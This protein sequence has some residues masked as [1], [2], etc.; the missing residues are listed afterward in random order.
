MTW[1]RI[2]IF[3]SADWNANKYSRL[4]K[5]N[6]G[7]YSIT[8]N[9]FVD[10][11]YSQFDWQD[12]NGDGYPDL[13]L[14]G[15]NG[16]KECGFL[17]INS[18]DKPFYLSDTIIPGSQKG[19][20]GFGDVDND[21][22]LDAFVSGS[23]YYPSLNPYVI[24]TNT[25]SDSLIPESFTVDIHTIS[26]FQF[27]DYDNDNDLDF[28]INGKTEPGY[29]AFT[30][31]YQNTRS[32]N[33]PPNPPANIYSN[34]QGTTVYL[35]WDTASDN[36]TP[37]PIKS[38][39]YNIYVGTTSQG[40]DIVSPLASIP[41]GFRKIA[42]PGY[43]QDTA[44]T[45]K[46]LEAGTYYWGVQAIDNALGTSAFSIEDT[47]IIKDRF[48][49]SSFSE[50]PPVSS[51]AMFFDC[52]HDNDFDMVLN[53]FDNF[54]IASY[55]NGFDSSNYNLIFYET[56]NPIRTITPNDYNNDNL[57]DIS[58]SGDYT[59]N[60]SI[61]ETSIA[62]F[63]YNSPYN[64]TKQDSLIQDMFYD[65]VIWAD[66][67]NDGLQDFITSGLNLDTIP[68]TVIYQNSGNGIFI[69]ID[70]TI[71]GFNESGAVAA[72]FDNDMDI[73]IIIYG[74]DSLDNPNTYLYRN[75]GEFNFSEQ[76]IQNN[77]LFRSQP[78]FGIYSGDFDLNGK[79]DVYLV[80]QAT[81]SNYYVKVLL[82]NN[83]SFTDAN[84]PIK[85]WK[86]FTSNFWADY[87]YD[88][89]IDIF[90]TSTGNS[91]DETRLYINNNQQLEEKIY[92]LSAL[93]KL[94]QPFI[95]VNLDNQNGL[96]FLMKK[97]AGNYIQFFDNYAQ[98][99]K[100]TTAPA[101]LHAAMDSLDVVFSWD[102]LPDCPAC[103]YN[104]RVGTSPDMVDIM[105][106]M[107]DTATGF[108]YVI[109]PGNAYMNS[110]W[111]LK[112]LEPETYYW[113]VQAVDAAN[114]GGPWAPLQSFDVTVVN[115]AFTGTTVCL[116]DTTTFTD[117]SATS[118]GSIIEWNWDF[119]D[120]TTSALQNPVHVFDSA[121][122][123]LVKLTAYSSTSDS[124]TVE[125][126]VIVKPKP[127]ARF[128]STTVCQG[129]PT[130]FIKTGKNSGLNITN[131]LLQ[132]GDGESSTSLGDT[133]TQG[134]I[135]V[136]SFTSSLLLNADNGC[137]DSYQTTVRVGGLP[138]VSITD[139]GAI[140]PI[141]V[142]DTVRLSVKD[143]SD[144]TYA[145]KRNG[146]D[147]GIHENILEITREDES[148]VY[149]VNVTN[150]IGYCIAQSSTKNV[151]VNSLPNPPT[152]Q[153]SQTPVGFCQGDSIVLSVNKGY[154]AYSWKNGSGDDISAGKNYQYVAKST[155]DYSVEITNSDG[156]SAISA[157]TI[158]VT[159]YPSPAVPNLAFSGQQ[160]KCQ[161]ETLL[162]WITNPNA[163][164]QY[165]WYSTVGI[166]TGETE[167]SLLI[168]TD[169]NYYITATSS[170]GCESSSAMVEATFSPRPLRPV[171]SETGTV[172]KCPDELIPVSVTRI[173]GYN[174]QWLLYGE[175]LPDA[176]SS[177]IY[178]LLPGQYRC[179]VSN[180]GCT[181]LS[182]SLI[183][184]YKEAPAK[185]LLEAEG[186]NV[187]II[188]CS[189]DTAKF[190][191]WYYDDVL[192]A[193]ANKAYYVA[194][195]N[196]GSYIVEI[197]TGGEC[198]RKSDPI[199]IGSGTTIKDTI[200]FGKVVLFPNPSTGEFILEMD[201]DIEGP[202]LI[203]IINLMGEVT[204]SRIVEK[205]GRYHSE[206]FNLN[207]QAVYIVSMQYEDKIISRRIMIIPE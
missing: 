37:T 146:E 116:E 123:Y 105:S 79:I 142:G 82:N 173:E 63:K 38:L 13:L 85:A 23:K 153:P 190:Y 47:F 195:Q 72:D 55:E 22:D 155:G 136:G 97:D 51:P 135:N 99:N 26:D 90:S 144:F 166:I 159:V 178:A 70:N 41:G 108:R 71:R 50:D 27:G 129:T 6:N 137:S 75:E 132:F 87:D 192:I 163:G 121:K 200:L 76:E 88:G 145:W 134:Y 95:A 197:N 127:D 139:E 100:Q 148:G 138:D 56:F 161:G 205:S 103:T 149:T 68:K 106:P 181:N 185:P 102:K 9:Y 15:S 80:G 156:C 101:N 39:T 42:R 117:A 8:N 128:T 31:I 110:G 35:S 48:T 204:E 187:W 86:E 77:K 182:D 167:D 18:K 58:V 29:N 113:S 183:I 46:N 191:R 111:R 141:C 62:L 74:K 44:W 198:W 67:N 193:G 176:D 162:N 25:G 96:D 19:S 3:L 104:I 114:T 177:A 124:S 171:L 150:T 33:T 119:G 20:I 40:T 165:Q 7:S 147:I 61:F 133:I 11:E 184:V 93:N 57:I 78:Y 21:G 10:L 16:L 186:P 66:F 188:G 126:S 196:T 172:S 73:D 81:N 140:S 170:N 91:P 59:D 4:W 14:E 69:K 175:E 53:G 109:G 17:Y 168:S 2:W 83:L 207:Q 203:R 92:S 94:L 60:S 160:G 98:F 32:P 169:G 131:S 202:V 28:I 45:L 43:I 130:K 201:N 206:A 122:T 36:N 1:T 180:K 118:K 154:A 34:V 89:D 30:Y 189:N 179:E 115:A 107:A 151:T 174:Y 12:F 158:T 199:V 24:Y 64:Y 120:G 112:G 54:F 152:I 164:N 65:Y 49:E 52:D 5:N 157:N 194:Y 125:K 84:L 143:S